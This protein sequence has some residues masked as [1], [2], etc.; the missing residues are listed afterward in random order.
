[1]LIRTIR[2]LVVIGLASFWLAGCSSQQEDEGMSG[3]DMTPATEAP[4]SSGTRG[5]TTGGD[6][7]S[8]ETMKPTVNPSTRRIVIPD[9]GGGVEELDGL[10]YFDFDQAIVKR[11]GHSELDKHAE[12]L[13]ADRGLRIRLEGHCDERGT[14]EYNLA[15]GERRANAVKAY[16]QAQGVFASQMETISYG[17][18]KPAADGHNEA[19]WAQNRR[20]EIIYK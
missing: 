4:E 12:A 10:F 17:E 19:A 8:A 3:D 18:E 2:G 20:V 7:Q 13:S 16:L 11:A 14:R 1:M 5:G 6:M 15:L 9:I